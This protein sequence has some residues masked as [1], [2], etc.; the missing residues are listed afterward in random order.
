MGSRRSKHPNL[1]LIGGRRLFA[2][3]SRREIGHGF[4]Q[5]LSDW[6]Q[7]ARRYLGVSHANRI[8]AVLVSSQNVSAAFLIAEFFPASLAPDRT[9]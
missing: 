7:Q 8:P 5:L 1:T 3:A 6:R 2:A 4:A 9:S